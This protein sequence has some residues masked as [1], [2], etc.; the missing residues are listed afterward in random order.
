[1]ND[2]PAIAAELFERY[3]AAQNAS[4][5]PPSGEQGSIY[6]S[7]ARSEAHHIGASPWE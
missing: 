6:S 4:K 3:M 5:D 7:L 2:L 1:M